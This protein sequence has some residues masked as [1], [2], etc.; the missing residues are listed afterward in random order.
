MARSGTLEELAGSG[1]EVEIRAQGLS[2]ELVRSLALDARILRR[3]GELL[4]LAL[5]GRE[6]VPAM[7]AALVRGG[8]RVYAV[9]PRRLPLEELFVRIMEERSEA[10]TGAPAP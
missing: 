8:A 10:E 9:S 2:E 5:E 7:V 1:L 6:A 4:V 3:E